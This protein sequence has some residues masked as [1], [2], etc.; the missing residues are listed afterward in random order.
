MTGKPKTMRP[1]HRAAIGGL[2]AIWLA[3]LAA[4]QCD[5]DCRCAGTCEERP[6]QG[7]DGAADFHTPRPG[8]PVEAKQG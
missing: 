7:R 6:A 2:F 8:A 1:V 3:P 4:G 5:A